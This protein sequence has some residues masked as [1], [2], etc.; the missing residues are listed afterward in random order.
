MWDRFSI[1]E[2]TTTT[3]AIT[4]GIF[5]ELSR[6]ANKAGRYNPN[7]R[8]EIFKRLEEESDNPET[9]SVNRALCSTIESLNSCFW[10]E[11]WET[12]H[13]SHE[14][15]P[16]LTQPTK[17]KW[18]KAGQLMM[19]TADALSNNPD[20]SKTFWHKIYFPMG[21][22][23]GLSQARLEQQQLGLMAEL[24]TG[25][26]IDHIL[27]VLRR[28][29]I[30]VYKSDPQ[31]DLKQGCDLVIKMDNGEI[32]VQIKLRRGGGEAYVEWLKG[33]TNEIRLYYKNNVT[34]LF[35]PES[36]TP[37]NLLIDKLSAQIPNVM[38]KKIYAN[39]YN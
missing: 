8:R 30:K 16:K 27:H 1:H 2:Q 23:V 25:K 6:F 31:E 14:G 28:T 9:S 10:A 35:D 34:E 29:D 13:E 5:Q 4:P 15:E 33:T 24:A 21:K 36:G 3:G 17:E 11:K 7:E 20:L 39:K 19:F 32:P 12:E 22:S 38:L 37:T 26:A 18:A